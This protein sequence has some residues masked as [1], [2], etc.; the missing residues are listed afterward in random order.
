MDLCSPDPCRYGTHCIQTDEESYQCVKNLCQPS[1]CENAGKCIVVN[2][3]QTE[4]A[5]PK[6]WKGKRCE[7]KKMILYSPNVCLAKIMKVF[8]LRGPYYFE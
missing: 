4:C 2:N 1:P 3:E 6:G 8:V 5:C 7:G